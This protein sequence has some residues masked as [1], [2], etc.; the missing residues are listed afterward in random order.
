MLPTQL[1][2]ASAS[3][4]AILDDEA[5]PRSNNDSSNSSSSSNNK[6]GY[7]FLKRDGPK[8]KVL[9]VPPRAGSHPPRSALFANKRLLLTSS[10]YKSGAFRD[11][12]VLWMQE[13]CPADILPKIIAYA[14]PR[15]A[16]AL[17][18]TN[19]FWR[20]SFQE[21]STWKVMCEELYKVSLWYTWIRSTWDNG[22]YICNGKFHH[23]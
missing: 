11:N 6:R 5:R 3:R 20:H 19:R 9:G 21:E 12:V 16:A 1:L 14:G 17:N 8:S 22:G 2:L 13:E 18:A 23:V 10:H 4:V 7:G 15:M